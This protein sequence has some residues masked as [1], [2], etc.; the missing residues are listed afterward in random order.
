MT[1]TSGKPT[2]S[3]VKTPPVPNKIPSFRLKMGE[4]FFKT[5]ESLAVAIIKSI[6]LNS[7]TGP[8]F[9]NCV[10]GSS[11][12]ACTGVLLGVGM[13]ASQSSQAFVFL[14][15]SGAVLVGIFFVEGISG[16]FI[17]IFWS[18]NLNETV[19]FWAYNRLKLV[20]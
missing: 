6:P 14:A 18:L 1:K 11:T 10:A 17:S 13:G 9:K 15:G 2:F 20:K 12:G 7:I 16:L 5:T 19:P 4:V 8:G 3:H